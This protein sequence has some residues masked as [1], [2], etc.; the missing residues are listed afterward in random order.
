[1][2]QLQDMSEAPTYNREETNNFFGNHNSKSESKEFVVKGGPWEHK[3]PDTT[4]TE[5]FPS[6]GGGGGPTPQNPPTMSW[7]PRR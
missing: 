3:A 7:G 2:F 5:D 6:F 1:M 4:S